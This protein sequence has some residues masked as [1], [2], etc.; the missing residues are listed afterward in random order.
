[1]IATRDGVFFF[2][3]SFDVCTGIHGLNDPLTRDSAVV[4]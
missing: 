2:S 3:S 4:I 1:M